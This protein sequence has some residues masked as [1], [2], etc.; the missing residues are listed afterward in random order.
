MA[1]FL[2]ISTNQTMFLPLVCLVPAR[3]LIFEVAKWAVS[4]LTHCSNPFQVDMFISRSMIQT[5]NNTK[6]VQEGKR[7]QKKETSNFLFL[8]FQICVVTNL[9]ACSCFCLRSFCFWGEVSNSCIWM[10]SAETPCWEIHRKKTAKFLMMTFTCR[11]TFLYASPISL[12]LFFLFPSI[13]VPLL[14]ICQ[15]FQFAAPIIVLMFRHPIPTT[16]FHY[17]YSTD[18]L[19]T[20]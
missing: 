16:G 7:H 19:H 20:R 1:I 15:V 18:K 14:D 6:N 4:Y 9:S 3:L 10:I 13:P 5:L 11:S 12:I 17:V 8:S 2:S